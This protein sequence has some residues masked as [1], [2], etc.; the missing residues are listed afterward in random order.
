MKRGFPILMFA[1]CLLV[2]APAALAQEM[3]SH[4][5]SS[6]LPDMHFSMIPGMPT[7]ATGAVVQ[8]DPS[9]GGSIILAKGSAGCTFPWHWHTPTE[10]LM[11]V[12]GTAHL[13]AKDG[14]EMTLEAGGFASMPSRHVHKFHCATACTLYVSSDTAFDMHYVN[15]EGKE[16]SP[17]EA[18]KAVKETAAK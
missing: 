6:N 13:Q 14:P 4:P 17:D 1:V 11:M 2:L 10:N 18:L 9:K 15:A 7:C 8:G 12:S 3:M 5:M 16:I